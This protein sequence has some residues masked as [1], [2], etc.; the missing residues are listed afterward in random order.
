M[1]IGRAVPSNASLAL[2]N[3]AALKPRL[4]ADS[5]CLALPALHRHVANPQRLA[6][7]CSDMPALP[8]RDGLMLGRAKQNPASRALPRNA[9]T[10]L[11]HDW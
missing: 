9:S 11:C 6:R 8:N 2:P 3:T 1:A 4:N 7:F 10:A 5:L